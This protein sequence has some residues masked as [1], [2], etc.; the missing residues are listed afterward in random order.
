MTYVER[1]VLGAAEHLVRALD[2]AVRRVVALVDLVE[3]RVRVVVARRV[4]QLYGARRRVE[5][6]AHLLLRER[7]REV[8]RLPTSNQNE[9]VT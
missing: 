4:A 6:D 5:L 9:L 8:R 3:A 1:L 7:R 2:L